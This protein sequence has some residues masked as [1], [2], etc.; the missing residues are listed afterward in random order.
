MF[1]FILF[2]V[3][4]MR[5]RR[6][7][8]RRTLLACLSTARCTTSVCLGKLVEPWEL[9]DL[10]TSSRVTFRVTFRVLFEILHRDQIS[11]IAQAGPIHGRLIVAS[12]DLPENFILSAHERKPS[13]IAAYASGQIVFASISMI[14]KSVVDYFRNIYR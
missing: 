9:R 12:F 11:R 2:I 13:Y 1:L 7:I 4:S 5:R 10:V 6:K 3:E 14:L 8:E